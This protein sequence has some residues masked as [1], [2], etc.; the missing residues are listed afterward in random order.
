GLGGLT[1]IAV[2]GTVGG[3]VMDIGFSLYG[4]LMVLAA[5]QTFRFARARQLEAHRAWALRL[6]A[7]AIGSWLYRMDYGFWFLL[8][9]GA[10][11]TPDFHG[12]FDAVMDFFF[13]VPNLLVAEVFIRAHRTT[14][15]PALAIAAA[16]VLAG[17][18]SFL[19]L[20]TYYFIRF[21]WGPAILHRF[22]G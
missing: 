14:V 12:P 15:P 9:K 8:A 22:V 21:F 20:G 17:A 18:A 5:G 6:F 3:R 16:I 13:W 2:K 19:L 11:H 10:G 7:L 4:V 1:F